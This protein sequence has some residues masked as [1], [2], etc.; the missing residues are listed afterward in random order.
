MDDLTVEDVRTDLERAQ[1]KLAG[2]VAYSERDE[3]LNVDESHEVMTAVVEALDA[4]DGVL[5]RRDLG[6]VGEDE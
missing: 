1:R 6:V 3:G 4:L 2:V 5:G